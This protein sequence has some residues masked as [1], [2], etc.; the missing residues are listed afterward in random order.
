MGTKVTIEPIYGGWMLFIDVLDENGNIDP[1]SR[2]FEFK[3]LI[4]AINAA[5]AMKLHIDN[6]DDLPIHQ[7]SRAS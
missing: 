4:E 6:I 2:F 7:Y 3:R 1:A 5:S